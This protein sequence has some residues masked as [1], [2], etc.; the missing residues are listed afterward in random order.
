[1]IVAINVTAL[2]LISLGL[3]LLLK[4]NN[5][6]QKNGI[7]DR[8]AKQ[9]YNAVVKSINHKLYRSMK[10]HHKVPYH[11]I[12]DAEYEKALI[13][14]YPNISKEDWMR[15]MVIVQKVAFS[16]ESITEEEASF[17]YRIYNSRDNK[18]D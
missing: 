13:K 12:R 7:A 3:I 15:F 8:L 6:M 16:K 5:K 14:T 11:Q 10:R 18:P 4:H 17:C 9:R 1:M 2:I